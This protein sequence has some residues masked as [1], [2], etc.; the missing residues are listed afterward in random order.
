MPSVLAQCRQYAKRTRSLLELC[1]IS[2][3]LTD[4]TGSILLHVHLSGFASCMYWQVPNL[5]WSV[6]HVSQSCIIGM[7]SYVRHRSKLPASNFLL[8]TNAAKLQLV[9]RSHRWHTGLS[10]ASTPT[11]T[12]ARFAYIL[13]VGELFRHLV[14]VTILTAVVTAL[15]VRHDL[16]LSSPPI[17]IPPTHAR[18]HSSGHAELDSH[19]SSLYP[20]IVGDI[21]RHTVQASFQ[22]LLNRT[23]CL[24][25]H[26]PACARLDLASRPLHGFVV[27]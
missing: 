10:F 19:L 22:P 14:A 11:A 2:C 13:V 3:R 20:L 16:P 21:H 12:V 27:K 26:I 18:I 24:F 9:L 4:R 1:S 8:D 5:S 7:H 25:S 6:T 15:H 23:V 17:I